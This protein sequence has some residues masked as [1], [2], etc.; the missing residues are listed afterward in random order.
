MSH[1]ESVWMGLGGSALLVGKMRMQIIEFYPKTRD[2]GHKKSNTPLFLCIMSIAKQ[3]LYQQVYC[4]WTLYSTY[5]Q[6]SKPFTSRT[7]GFLPSSADTYR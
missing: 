1:I 7:A 5:S 4:S 6:L 3:T 2:I